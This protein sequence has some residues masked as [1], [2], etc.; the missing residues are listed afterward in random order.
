LKEGDL[1]VKACAH[2]KRLRPLEKK[3]HWGRRDLG[4]NPTIQEIGEHMSG[5]HN[6]ISEKGVNKVT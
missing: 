2:E 4:G 1:L 6:V 5:A 3:R